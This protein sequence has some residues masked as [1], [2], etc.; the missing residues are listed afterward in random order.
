MSYDFATEKVCSHEVS[1]EASEI[2]ISKTYISFRKQPTNNRV[3]L[4]IDG[5][6]VPPSGLVS[7]PSLPF[8]NAEPYRIISGVSDLIYL[9]MG[10]DSPRLIQLIPGHS[11]RAAD[12]VK[13]LRLKVPTL[14][15]NVVNKHVVASALAPNSGTVFSFPDPR[16]TDKTQSLPTTARILGAYQQLGIVPGRAVTGRKLYPGWQILPDPTSPDETGKILKLESPLFNSDPLI[17]L[18][19]VTD[20]SNCRRCHGTQ[21]EFDYN[22]TDNSYETVQ[23]TDLMAQEFDKFV[24]TRLGSHFRWSW[25]GS[26]LIDRIG[27]KGSTAAATVNSLITLDISKAFQTYQNIKSQQDSKFPFQ[28]VSDS[29]YP[30]SLVGINVQVPPQDPTIAIVTTTIVSRSRIPVPLKR[31]IGNPSPFTILGNPQAFLQRG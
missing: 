17:Q 19:Y 3:T 16:W 8:I 31:M 20:L 23:N 18:S 29:E 5:F 11:V 25:L 9:R 12:L 6:L 4:Y 14:N 1:L 10:A 26:Q 7:T 28:A 21:I 22:I 13:D 2:D 27:S 15:W 30:L 24:F